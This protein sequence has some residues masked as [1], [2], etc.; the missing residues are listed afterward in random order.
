MGRKKEE[1][2]FNTGAAVACVGALVFALGLFGTIVSYLAASND[3][4]GRWTFFYGAIAWGAIQFV[5]GCVQAANFHKAK[6]RVRKEEEED[7][8]DDELDEHDDDRAVDAR[9]GDRAVDTRVRTDRSVKVR[10][11]EDD[12]KEDEDE[13]D[14]RPVRRRKEKP[15]GKPVPTPVLI[16]CG[17]AGFLI[18]GGL[19][20]CATVMLV[21]QEFWNAG[22]GHGHEGPPPPPGNVQVP[23]PPDPIAE[24]LGP[25]AAQT[26]IHGGA[27]DPTFRDQAPDGGMLVG[28]DVGLGK[29]LNLDVVKS[30]QPIYRTAKGEV[31]GR[32]FGTDFSQV[33]Q[34]RAKAGYA[35]GGINVKAGLLVNGFSVKFM[36]VKG[37]ALDPAD[38]YTSPWIGDQTGGNGPTLLGGDGKLIV[39]IIGKRNA[40]DCNGLGLLKK[41]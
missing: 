3:G 24:D 23:P 7:D 10:H 37:N 38:S 5:V 18:L 25:K 28:L 19:F 26:E 31:A 17:V 27:F 21:I 12:G 30:V 16:G 40:R 14:E 20:A 39:G 36:R 11:A 35:V 15:Q 4:R 6:R 29:F 22:G 9:P 13:D 2:P 33:H 41:L 34:V 32:K 8:E 1:Q